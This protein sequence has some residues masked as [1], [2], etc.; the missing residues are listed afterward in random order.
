MSVSESV[1]RSISVRNSFSACS[2]FSYSSLCQSVF[3]VGAFFVMDGVAFRSASS[4][5][6]EVIGGR[7]LFLYEPRDE[8]LVRRGV[9]VIAGEGGER[10]NDS[11]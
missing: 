6:R 8:A 9:V 4:V 11:S 3:V 1:N 5:G 7:D 2:R 10:E